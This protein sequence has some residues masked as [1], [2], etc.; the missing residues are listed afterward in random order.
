[1][2]IEES[3]ISEDDTLVCELIFNLHDGKKNLQ[4]IFISDKSNYNRSGVCE[5]N[6]SCRTKTR[7]L[8][9]A[10]IC[11]KVWYCSEK[12]AMEYEKVHKVICEKVKFDAVEEFEV[13]ENN[14]S[15]KSNVG[16]RN[17]GNTCYINTAL[18]CLSNTQIL[19]NYFL[20]NV[21]KVA[22][23]KENTLGSKGVIA[24]QIAK[25]I[26]QIHYG[27]EKIISIFQFKKVVSKLQPIVI[28]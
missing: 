15:L 13:E 18:Q 14:F 6:K 11:K 26:K 4:K 25:I 16:I 19:A 1:M 20:K 2:N 9:Y 28:S 17:L 12:C 7:I 8:T 24:Y 22:I 3:G 10:C 23:N 5:N 27:Q 21:F